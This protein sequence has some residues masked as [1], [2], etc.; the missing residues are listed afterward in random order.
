[1]TELIAN[2]A[3]PSRGKPSRCGSQISIRLSAKFTGSSA[4]L[5]RSGVRTSPTL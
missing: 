5:S 3:S 2:A 4:A 1:M